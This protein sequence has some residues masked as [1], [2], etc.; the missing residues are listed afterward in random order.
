MGIKIYHGYDYAKLINSIKNEKINLLF[1]LI[2]KRLLG[3]L[4]ELYRT[5]GIFTVHTSKPNVY[6][7]YAF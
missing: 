6:P 1:P 2:F 4:F 7:F 3:I 5:T